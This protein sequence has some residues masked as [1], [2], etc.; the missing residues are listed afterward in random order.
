MLDGYKGTRPRKPLHTTMQRQIA[1]DVLERIGLNVLAIEDLEAD[2][3]IAS[4]VNY[5]KDDYEHVYIHS[6]DSDLF[7][8]VG[9]NVEVVPLTKGYMSDGKLIVHG[10][11]INM[12]NWET[13]VNKDF[14]IP[15]NTLTLDK[16]C[17]GESGDNIPAIDKTLSKV[18]LSSIPKEQYVKCGDNKLL[19]RWISDAVNGDEK[20]LG[21]LDLIT[22]I[23]ADFGQVP[24]YEERFD[25]S[26]CDEFGVC[27]K[28]KY[29]S[30]LNI[31]TFRAE[32][33]LSSYIDSYNRR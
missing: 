18:I 2:D 17:K 28:N 3:V 8:L 21:T 10:K 30:K 15:Y 33:V 23:I 31:G 26:L 7:Y 6:L 12:R 20:V 32:N 9:D 11:H 1:E 19:K 5:Y 27:F 24:I 16:L 13:Q 29:T 22:P 14:I 4:V 25:K